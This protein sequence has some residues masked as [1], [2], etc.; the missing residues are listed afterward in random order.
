MFE[1]PRF[2]DQITT[3]PKPD[4]YNPWPR[5]CSTVLARDQ[6]TECGGGVTRP[7]VQDVTGKGMPG[8]GSVT[9]DACTIL[10]GPTPDRTRAHK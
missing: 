3:L 8:H 4:R 10:R 1:Y 7:F 6:I 9:R 5:H 2:A